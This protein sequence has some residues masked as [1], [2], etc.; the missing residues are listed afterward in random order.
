MAFI[1][2]LSAIHSIKVNW[3]F[4]IGNNSAISIFASF[5]NGRDHVKEGICSPRCKFFFR[6]DLILEGLLHPGKQTESHKSYFPL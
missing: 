1:A 2:I 4:L 6:K 3:N 5:L